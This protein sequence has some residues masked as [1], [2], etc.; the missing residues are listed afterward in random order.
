MTTARRVQQQ[1]SAFSRPH[2]R[3]SN[4]TCTGTEPAVTGVDGE[5][6]VVSSSARLILQVWRSSARIRT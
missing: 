2:I 1:S 4:R 3:S 6:A 5:L